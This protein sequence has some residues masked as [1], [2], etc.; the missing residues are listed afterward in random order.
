MKKNIEYGY[1]FNDFNETFEEILNIQ[2]DEN[3]TQELI[4]LGCLFFV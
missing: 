2:N 4:V 3:N 1:L